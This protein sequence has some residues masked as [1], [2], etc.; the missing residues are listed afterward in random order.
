MAATACSVAEQK[1][2]GNCQIQRQE[3]HVAPAAFL[4]QMGF[5]AARAGATGHVFLV[6]ISSLSLL[7]LLV[8]SGSTQGSRRSGRVG[9]FPRHVWAPWPE[10]SV[11]HG[12]HISL[13]LGSSVLP[14]PSLLHQ[15][16]G[17][18]TGAARGLCAPQL[19]QLELWALCLRPQTPTMAETLQRSKPRPPRAGPGA[20]GGV[21]RRAGG[22]SSAATLLWGSC[23]RHHP[24]AHQVPAGIHRTPLYR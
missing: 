5:P 12:D 4:L 14:S 11:S 6:L 18:I 7:Q 20:G 24:A 2:R 3:W 15:V 1:S 21:C 23:P 16:C 19:R 10:F 8:E 22:G 17:L 13:G 9:R